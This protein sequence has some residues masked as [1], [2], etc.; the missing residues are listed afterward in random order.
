[1]GQPGG[2]EIVEEMCKNALKVRMFGFQGPSRTLTTA[3]DL[4]R[5]D[6]VILTLYVKFASDRLL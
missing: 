2:G 4:G 3:Y 1:M 5:S 6:I